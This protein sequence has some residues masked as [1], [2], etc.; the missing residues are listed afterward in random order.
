MKKKDLGLS[1][2]AI[3]TFVLCFIFAIVFWFS[4]SYGNLDSLN[5]FEITYGI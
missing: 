4:V 5:I 2:R 1:I 3:L